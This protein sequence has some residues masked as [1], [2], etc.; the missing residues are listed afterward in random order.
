[1]S[2]DDGV[3]WQLFWADDDEVPRVGP[4]R[5]RYLESLATRRATNKQFLTIVELVK[6]LE[7]MDPT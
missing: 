4:V 2:V 1:M 6:A 3:L 7:E 5:R